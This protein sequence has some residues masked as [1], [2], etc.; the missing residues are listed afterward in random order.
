[1]GGILRGRLRLGRVYLSLMHPFLYILLSA[2][3]LSLLI[4]FKRGRC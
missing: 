1:M 4:W 2:I 3:A